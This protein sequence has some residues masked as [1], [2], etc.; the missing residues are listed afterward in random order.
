MSK[1]VV[2]HSA[3]GLRPGVEGWA[4][5]L[6][7]CGHE[8]WTPDLFAGRRFDRLEEGIAHR[9]EVGVPELMRRLEAEL[10]ELP[11][12]VVY[13]GFSMGAASAGYYAATRP[14]S[15]GAVLVGGV[16]PLAE[17]GVER[18]P[19]AVPAQVH[20]SAEDRYV[21]RARVESFEHALDA[22]RARLEIHVY[23]GSEH[24]LA[25]PDSPGYDP[26]SAELL[27]ARVLEFLQRCG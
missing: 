20:F 21:D 24:L 22:S 6:R 14:G 27:L 7:E 23:S 5:R 26:A 13:A 10:A 19:A 12:D 8:V 17:L 3:Q 25:D 4:A 11:A 2:L 1:V 16:T 15:R 9:D 18:W